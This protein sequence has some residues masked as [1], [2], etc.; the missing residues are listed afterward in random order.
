MIVETEARTDTATAAGA[1]PVGWPSA[2]NRTALNVV[3]RD[4]GVATEN[5]P[6]SSTGPVPTSYVRPETVARTRTCWPTVNGSRCT[7]TRAC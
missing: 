4:T 7:V 1:A 6:A 2:P 5:W 3:V